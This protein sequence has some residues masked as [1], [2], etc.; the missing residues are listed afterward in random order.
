MSRPERNPEDVEALVRAHLRRRAEDIDAEAVLSG[1][2]ARL[3][4][5]RA[6]AKDDSRGSSRRSWFR[7]ALGIAAAAAVLLAFA[8]GLYLIPPAAQASAEVLVRQAER[9]HDLP[10][11]RC[12]LI[13][14]QPEPGLA[15]RFPLLAQSRETRLWTRGDRFWMDSVAPA[16]LHRRWSWGRDDRHRVWLTR[17]RDEGVRFDPDEVPEGLSVACDMLS[18][19]PAPLLGALLADFNLTLDA[20]PTAPAGVRVVRAEL[21]PG[22]THPTLRA[23]VLEIDAES[24]VLQ[25]VTLSRALRGVPLATVTFTLVETGQLADDQYQLEG[26]LDRD[27]QVYTHDNQP[28]RR[29]AVLLRVL[30]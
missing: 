25:K 26:H 28:L 14:H 30:P 2:R 18:M 7:W 5:G 24:K 10:V 13:T 1:V 12:Y 27:A 23:A 22:H 17:S 29:R 3:E 20:S 11:D 19:Q 4:R 15:D 16:P 8:G 21:K 9:T 6:A